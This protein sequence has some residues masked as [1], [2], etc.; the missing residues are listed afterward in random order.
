[1][2]GAALWP[3]PGI[4]RSRIH[5]ESVLPFRAT[6]QSPFKLSHAGTLRELPGPRDRRQ[7]LDVLAAK[8]GSGMRDAVQGRC[9]CPMLMNN[10]RGTN[11]SAFLTRP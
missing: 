1:M 7:R 9:H 10:R 6:D 4:T 5:A 3:R 8:R 2:T 11:P